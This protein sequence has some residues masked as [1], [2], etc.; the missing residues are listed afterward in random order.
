MEKM[1]PL[2]RIKVY[3]KVAIPLIL[4]SMVKSQQLEVVLQSK[5]FSGSPVRTYLHES[6]MGTLDYLLMG[7]FILLLVAAVVLYIFFGIGRFVVPG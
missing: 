6:E 2:Q 3:S 4:G 7:F 5:A 1:N